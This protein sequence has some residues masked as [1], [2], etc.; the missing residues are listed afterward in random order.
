MLNTEQVDILILS[1]NCAAGAANII[2]CILIINGVMVQ[3]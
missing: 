1:K 2:P 3:Y